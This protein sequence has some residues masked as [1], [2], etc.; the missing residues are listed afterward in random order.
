MYVIL[1]KDGQNISEGEVCYLKTSFISFNINTVSFAIAILTVFF[2]N[3]LIFLQGKRR[4]F[5]H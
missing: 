5:T 1:W 4:I 3:Y 2:G